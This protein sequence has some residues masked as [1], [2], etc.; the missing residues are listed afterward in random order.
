M[1][2][3]ELSTRLLDITSNPL[4]ALFFAC[5][6]GSSKK[7]PPIG[8]VIC[9]FPESA[10]GQDEVKFYDSNRVLL[11]SALPLIESE[12]KK[13]LFLVIKAGKKL[14]F[15]PQELRRALLGTITPKDQKETPKP[16]LA[17]PGPEFGIDE[18][19][20]VLA[21]MSFQKLL[22]LVKAEA[23]SFDGSFLNPYDLLNPYYVRAGMINERITAQSGCFIISGLDVRGIETRLSCSRNN[24]TCKRIIVTNKT[25][26]LR[27][28]RQLNISFATLMPDLEHLGRVFSSEDDDDSTHD[29]FLLD[30]LLP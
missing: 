17:N 3:F 14:K 28:L 30:Y 7:Q 21:Q 15:S 25:S 12:E 29:L 26:I 6:D 11:L 19:L 10:Q 4:V 23:P 13:A 20:F 2:H 27:E 24:K 9:Y 8:E 22:R 16:N 18:K 5:A 1:Q